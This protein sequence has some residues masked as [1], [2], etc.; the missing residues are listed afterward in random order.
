[1]GPEIVSTFGS[2]TLPTDSSYAFKV[3]T[4]KLFSNYKMWNRQTSQAI[5]KD[6]VT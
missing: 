3:I 5:G 2:D 4:K 1:M 6:Y